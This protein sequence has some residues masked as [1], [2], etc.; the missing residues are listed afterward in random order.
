M[1]SFVAMARQKLQTC[2]AFYLMTIEVF[3]TCKF[4]I[5][6]LFLLVSI[7]LFSNMINIEVILCVLT[8]E[9]LFR[10]VVVDGYFRFKYSSSTY[11]H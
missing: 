7:E 8:I 1:Y 3:F 4:A 11:K 5:T 10:L 9:I 6:K 2:S